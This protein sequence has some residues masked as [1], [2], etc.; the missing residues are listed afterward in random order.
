MYGESEERTTK[1]YFPASAVYST[2]LHLL[3]IVQ[4]GQRK[5]FETVINIVN[6]E[7]NIV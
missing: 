2:D 6:P 4:D 7:K 5:L 3:G 1:G